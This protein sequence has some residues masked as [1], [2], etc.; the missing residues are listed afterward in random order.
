M[1]VCEPRMASTAGDQRLSGVACRAPNKEWRI[2]FLEQSDAPKAAR[3]SIVPAGR[4][5]ALIDSAIDH[6][7]KG[8]PLDASSELTLIGNEWRAEQ[9]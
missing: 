2:E 1:A 8:D 6:M 3:S 9:K 4:S 5:S 7:I